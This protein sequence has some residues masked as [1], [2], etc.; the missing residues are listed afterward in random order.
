LGL[1]ALRYAEPK[2]AKTDLYSRLDLGDPDKKG[3]D[4]RLVTLSDGKGQLLG[5]LIVGKRRYDTFGG[6]NDGVYVRT[7]GQPQAWLANGSLDLPAETVDWLDRKL[8]EIPIDK[9]KSVAFTGADG[10][11][12]AI[13]RAKAGDPFAFEGGMPAGQKLKSAES[14]DDIGRALS[15]FDFDDVKKAVDMPFPDKGVSQAVYVTF[16]G[17]TVTVA[18][19]EQDD[20]T[21]KADDKDKKKYWIRIEAAGT[22]DAAKEADALNK[23]VGGWVYAVPDFKANTFKT[24]L[25]DLIEPEKSS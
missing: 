20:P 9:I 19:M 4:A 18:M 1:T 11:K 2:T 17:L 15:F 12:L 3:S 22:G 10:A 14:L 23:R 25:T 7:P 13:A 21:K 8:T 16:D 24:K 6:G 5:Q